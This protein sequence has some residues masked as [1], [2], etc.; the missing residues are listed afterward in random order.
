MVLAT[1]VLPVPVCPTMMMLLFQ[2]LPHR[3][4]AVASNVCSDCKPTD[5]TFLV[6]SCPLHIDLKRSNFFW[7]L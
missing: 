5:I 7:F 2:S 1:N 3:P 4:V 6:W